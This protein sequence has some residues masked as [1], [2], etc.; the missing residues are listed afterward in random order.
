[1]ML[2]P[3]FWNNLSKQTCDPVTFKNEVVHMLRGI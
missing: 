3:I 2:N 1:L